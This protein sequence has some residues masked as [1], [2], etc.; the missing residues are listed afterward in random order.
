MASLVLSGDTSGS[1]TVS[2]PAVAGSTTQ[3]LVNV[4]GTLAPIVS[5]TAS[6]TT[7][8]TSVDFSNIPSWVKRITLV[9]RGVSLSATAN[10]LVQIGTGGTATTSGYTGAF[11][12][13]TSAPVSSCT[14]ISTG[15]VLGT[16]SA[17]TSMNCFLTIVNLTGNNWVANGGFAETLGAR[18]GY[19]TG[20]VGLAGTLDF[21]RVT[22]TS[23]D[24]FDVNG[25]INILYE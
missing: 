22:T 23:T 1:I 16:N 3:T 17:A 2:A 12:V 7:G 5:G 9:M 21:I 25:G 15:F 10:F 4:S 6:T 20:S 13:I 11:A 18:A 19:V 24:T 14:A 8:G